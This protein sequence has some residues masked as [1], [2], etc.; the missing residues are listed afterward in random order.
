MLPVLLLTN[1]IISTNIAILIVITCSIKTCLHLAVYEEQHADQPDGLHPGVPRPGVEADLHYRPPLV[2]L[3]G[4]H[5]Q[6]RFL[7][8][9]KL[10]Q[11]LILMR[12]FKQFQDSNQKRHPK[13][14]KL[15]G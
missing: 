12:D 9:V 3:P 13:A 4:L 2:L 15:R 6:K 1:T 14:R 10:L 7:A 11:T 8:Q 5:E